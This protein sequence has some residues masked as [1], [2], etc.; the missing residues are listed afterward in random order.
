METLYIEASSIECNEDRRE[1]S[2]KIVPLGTGEVGNTNLGA[3]TFEAGSIEIGSERYA[4][5]QAAI[6]N[7]L[8]SGQA[9]RFSAGQFVSSIAEHIMQDLKHYPAHETVK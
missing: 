3:Y 8:N 4:S 5:Y 6:A 9:Q 2:G 1:I 7:Y